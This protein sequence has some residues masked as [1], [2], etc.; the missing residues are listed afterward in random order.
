M[1]NTTSAPLSASSDP[2]FQSSKVRWAKVKISSGATVGKV[3]N[4]TW[5]PVL[6]I[7][8]AKRDSMACRVLGDNTLARSITMSAVCPT[9]TGSSAGTNIVPLAD[10]AVVD[11]VVDDADVGHANIKPAHIKDAMTIVTDGA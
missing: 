4:S 6:S 9:T 10:D 5:A 11:A 8:S 2:N 7:T 1:A 3:I